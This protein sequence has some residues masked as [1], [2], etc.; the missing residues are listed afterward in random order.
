MNTAL[1]EGNR[2]L[3]AISDERVD[4]GEAHGMA[5]GCDPCDRLERGCRLVDGDFQQLIPEVAFV[6]GYQ[7]RRRGTFE[8]AIEREL[9]AGLGCRRGDHETGEDGR[10]KPR[11]RCEVEE[12]HGLPYLY[13]A[14]AP[15]HPASTRIETGQKRTRRCQEQGKI[16]L[17][18]V[19]SQCFEH[20]AAPLYPRRRVILVSA[21]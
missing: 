4:V 2:I 7:E 1:I 21:T 13:K 17:R 19:R 10:E 18:S 16:A 8:P 14:S 11:Q 6:L 9:D 20:H 15:A 3:I 12:A 5:A